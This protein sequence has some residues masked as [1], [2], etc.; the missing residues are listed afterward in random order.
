MSNGRL[1]MWRIFEFPVDQVKEATGCVT[2]VVPPVPFS[3]ER[4]ERHASSNNKSGNLYFNGVH[5]V[6]QKSCLLFCI[7]HLL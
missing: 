7:S 1:S 6:F 4:V 5:I 2:N 3:S